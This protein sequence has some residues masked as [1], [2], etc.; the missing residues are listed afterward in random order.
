MWGPW[1]QR[2]AEHGCTWVHEWPISGG[3]TDVG[4]GKADTPGVLDLGESLIVE[5]VGLVTLTSI[6]PAQEL[7]EVLSVLIDT[8]V[9]LRQARALQRDTGYEPFW[10]MW[11]AQGET[12]WA[13]QEHVPVDF[14][15]AR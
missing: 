1:L 4:T 12:F 5:G 3:A 7:G 14:S 13:A 2:V 15:L 10:N 11:A 9:E 8:P 6:S